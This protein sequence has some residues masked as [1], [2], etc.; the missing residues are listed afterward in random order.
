MD[1]VSGCAR[2]GFR[3]DGLVGG[4]KPAIQPHPWRRINCSYCCGMATGREPRRRR[5]G[6]RWRWAGFKTSSFFS[7]KKLAFQI[8]AANL[9]GVAEILLRYRGRPIGPEEIRFLR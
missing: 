4:R 8:P 6:A 9:G 2:S 1:K 3:K 5:C 7:K